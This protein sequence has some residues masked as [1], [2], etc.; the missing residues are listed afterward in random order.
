LAW[1]SPRACSSTRAT[2]RAEVLRSLRRLGVR[3]LIDDFGTGFSSLDRLRRYPIDALKIDR[4][5]VAGLGERDPRADT[6]LVVAILAMAEALGLD[7]IA[8]GV[9]TPEQRDR[10]LALGCPQAQGFLF[11][12]PLAPADVVVLAAGGGRALV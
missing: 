7:V 6:A 8:E 1:R 3:I 4:S 10:L 9:E 12:R 2:T 11:A 5:F